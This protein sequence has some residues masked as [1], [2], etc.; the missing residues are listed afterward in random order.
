MKQS[1]FA[2]PLFIAAI[3]AGS[4]Q[5]AAVCMPASELEAGLVD[6]HNETL[7]SQQSKD[8]YIWASGIGGSW[9]LVQYMNSRKHET[10]CV[11]AHGEN[12]IPNIDENTLASNAIDTKKSKLF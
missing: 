7:A 6:W 10:A 9:T 4:T 2:F 3:A 12:W 11:L 1:F 8:T 5:A